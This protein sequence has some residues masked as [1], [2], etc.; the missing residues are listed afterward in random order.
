MSEKQKLKQYGK[1]IELL[2]SMETDNTLA[3]EHIFK[4]L[5]HKIE[6]GTIQSTKSNKDGISMMKSKWK[7]AAA[8]AVALVAI[9]GVFSTTSY[10]Q[11]IIQSVLARF[12]VGNME[13]VQVDKERP[14]LGNPNGS[15]DQAGEAETGRVELPA[16]PKLTLEE[17]R[18]ATGI[19][20]PAPSWMADYEYVNT[21][22]Q[23]KTMVEVQYKQ[24]ERTVNFLISH[25]GNNGI[26]TTE[27][28]KT[29]V[30]EGTK[31]YFANGIVIWEKE[32]F[33]VEMYAREDFDTDT[34]K[35]IIKS[36][37]AGTPLTQDQIDDAKSK[38]DS[39]IHTERAAPAPAAASLDSK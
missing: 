37:A 7:T 27:Q 8:A 19:N 16:Q 36:F 25:G 18:A 9:G 35:K 38:L 30:F 12:Q 39:L 13:I 32:G 5:V 20:F 15:T 6:T 14:V 31:V 17:A 21:V 26:E 2:D 4:R 29:E 24:G 34:L 33:T 28:V 3:K 11:E 23:G 1:V 10:A 22:V